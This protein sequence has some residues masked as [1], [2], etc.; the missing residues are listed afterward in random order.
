MDALT[1]NDLLDALQRAMAPTPMVDGMTTPELAK[2]LGCSDSTVRRMIR[3]WLATGKAE[4]V[5]LRRLGMDG[6]PNTVRGYR[7]KISRE[8]AENQPWR[9]VFPG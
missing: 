1:T 7:L 9:L 8:G 4:V 6:R 5:E 2:A 3:Q